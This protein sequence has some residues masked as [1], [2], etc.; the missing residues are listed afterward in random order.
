M[1]TRC[2]LRQT[3][4][5]LHTTAPA[6]LKAAESC[7]AA[8]MLVVCGMAESERADADVAGI[9]AKTSAAIMA[10]LNRRWENLMVFIRTILLLIVDCIVDRQSNR[11]MTWL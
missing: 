2:P 10:R 11:L 5:V 8:L 1:E 7:S 9:A 6:A 4:L 3:T